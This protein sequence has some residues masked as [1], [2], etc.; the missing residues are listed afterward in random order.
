MA[1]LN[2]FLGI[3]FIHG[4]Y[5]RLTDEQLASAI[6][7]SVSEG[8]TG[9]NQYF[10]IPTE[11]LP[12]LQLLRGNAFGDA[13]ADLLQPVLRVLVNLG[14]GS[15]EN[16]WDQGPADI[17]TPFGLF[18]DVNP[19]DVLTALANGAQQG[20]NDFIAALQDIGSSDV[21]ELFDLGGGPADFSLPSL[22]DV[23]NTVSGAA[24]TL[25]ATLLPT[26]DI[27]NSLLTTLPA[28]NLSLFFNELLDGD[29][30]GAIGMPLAATTG[31]VTMAA[32]FEA[33][34]L[35][36]A[37]SDIAADFSDLFS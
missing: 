19:L 29:L 33:E 37:F 4:T 31:L 24:S 26:A 11:N 1:D 18:P 34:V 15:I 12:L 2:A 5:P 13:F 17:S 36:N 23:V 21:T 32:G 6:E 8:Y 27:I 20:W 14:Y 16:G 25:Y 9:S 3:M 28:Y 35:I 10:M 22:M 30:L 7:L